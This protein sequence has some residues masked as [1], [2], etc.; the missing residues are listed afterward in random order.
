MSTG[1]LLIGCESCQ[2]TPKA[3]RH[4]MVALCPLV[5]EE[6]K[7]NTR[8]LGKKKNPLQAQLGKHLVFLFF[9]FFNSKIYNFYK[10]DWTLPNF[11][12]FIPFNCEIFLGFRKV[13]WPVLGLNL[14]EEKLSNQTTWMR[15]MKMIMYWREGRRTQVKSARKEMATIWILKKVYRSNMEQIRRTRSSRSNIEAWERMDDQR[16]WRSRCLQSRKMQPSKK[17]HSG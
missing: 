10:M 16:R 12:W 2:Y 3:V 1:L 15:W 11:R 8:V 6:R 14:F 7:T 4:V 13:R 5:C 17:L 9:L